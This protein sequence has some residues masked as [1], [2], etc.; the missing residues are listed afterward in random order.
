MALDG[1]IYIPR[2]MKTGLGIQ[3]IFRL[4]PPQFQRYG[5]T[6]SPGVKH[7]GARH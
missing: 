4:L 5:W 2:F 6:L 7:L 1:M 3:A